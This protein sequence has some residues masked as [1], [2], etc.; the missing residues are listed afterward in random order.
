VIIFFEVLRLSARFGEF[1]G[2]NF[3]KRGHMRGGLLFKRRVKVF[4]GQTD[5]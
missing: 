2:G 1:D 5:E 4:I 3:R